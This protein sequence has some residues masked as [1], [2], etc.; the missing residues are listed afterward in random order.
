[1]LTC[2]GL[3]L[4]TVTFLIIWEKLLQ[5]TIIASI[6]TRG[7][8][9]KQANTVKNVDVILSSICVTGLLSFLVNELSEKSCNVNTKEDSK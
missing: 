3:D 4:F 1:M 9:Q 8:I 2:Q 6:S 7:E 5:L